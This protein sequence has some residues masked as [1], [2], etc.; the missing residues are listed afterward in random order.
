MTIQK[1]MP[2]S[3]GSHPVLTSLPPMRMRKGKA[4]SAEQPLNKFK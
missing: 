1:D 3:G 4:V 2:F